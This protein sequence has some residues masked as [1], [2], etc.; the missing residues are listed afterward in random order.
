MYDIC[1]IPKYLMEK[2]SVVAM[3]R[4]ISQTMIEKRKSFRIIYVWGS[5][6]P[7]KLSKTKNTFNINVL[8]DS[9]NFLSFP[10]LFFTVASTPENIPKRE[11]SS[12]STGVGGGG[13]SSSSGGGG[14]GCSLHT[15]IATCSNQSDCSSSAQASAAGGGPNSGGGGGGVG[16]SSNTHDFS[17]ITSPSGVDGTSESVN[18][19]ITNNSIVSSLNGQVASKYFFLL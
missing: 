10:L 3:K 5:Y 12:C 16:G 4:G 8:R 11:D 13:S 17:K 6:G 9:K 19:S 18:F 15:G 1:H 14:I 2:L 7:S